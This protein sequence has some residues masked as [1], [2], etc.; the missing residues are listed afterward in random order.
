M[1]QVAFKTSPQHT[2][3]MEV[4]EERTV[5]VRSQ[6][7]ASCKSY[8]SETQRP[9]VLDHLGKEASHRVPG[10]HAQVEISL[11]LCCTSSPSNKVR[12]CPSGCVWSRTYR[13]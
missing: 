5:H 7:E 9:K 13:K 8:V 6:E 12:M 1:V 3:D 10:V 4:D 11:T 2:V